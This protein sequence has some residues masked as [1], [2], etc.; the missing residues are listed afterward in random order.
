MDEFTYFLSQFVNGVKLGSVYAMVDIGYSMVYGILRLINFAHDN[1]M[2][3]G[4]YTI[5]FL[6][7]A[8]GMPLWAAI[9]I[10]VIISGCLFYSVKSIYS[11]FRQKLYK[12]I[13]LPSQNLYFPHQ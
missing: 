13:L 1:I 3:V 12:L 2:T 5:L 7:T 6:S 4:V 9:I 11:V 8:F 10:S